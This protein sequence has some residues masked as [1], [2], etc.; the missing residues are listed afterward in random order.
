[1]PGPVVRDFQSSLRNDPTEHDIIKQRILRSGFVP[2]SGPQPSAIVLILETDS[3]KID[4]YPTLVEGLSLH[5]DI[6]RAHIVCG[7]HLNLDELAPRA[8]ITTEAVV[9]MS[10]YMRTL[11]D[12]KEYVEGNK[13]RV[14]FM[15]QDSMSTYFGAQ[16]IW[17]LIWNLS[18]LRGE[19][20]C[21]KVNINP[22]FSSDSELD[23]TTLRHYCNTRTTVLLDVDLR[24]ILYETRPGAAKDYWNPASGIVGAEYQASVAFAPSGLGWLG[25]VGDYNPSID[26]IMAMCGLSS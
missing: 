10:D 16:N 13:A 14:L 8:I 23:L 4:L 20:L 11:S 24:H 1:M 6:S 22:L 2:Y 26:A 19:T 15:A 12:I 5:A 17:E 18:W 21:T 7:Q 25:Y 9:W 3:W